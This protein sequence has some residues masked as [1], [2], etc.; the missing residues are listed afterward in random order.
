MLVDSYASDALIVAGY[1]ACSRIQQSMESG[2]NRS[3]PN[4]FDVRSKL[5]YSPA[6]F[7]TPLLSSLERIDFLAR[8]LRV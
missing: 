2:N 1:P 3:N 4:L 5:N 8:E 7:R 6:S